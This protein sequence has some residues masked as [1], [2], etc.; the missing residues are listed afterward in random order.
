MA[1]GIINL[2]DFV[3]DLSA[4][5]GISAPYGTYGN[6]DINGDTFVDILNF[7]GALA[8]GC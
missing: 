1:T 5:T 4:C 8:D 3:E 6:A 7:I 2:L